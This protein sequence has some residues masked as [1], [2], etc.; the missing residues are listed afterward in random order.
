MQGVP[1]KKGSDHEL[2]K[3]IKD[4]PVKEVA[5]EAITTSGCFTRKE[6]HSNSKQSN[7]EEIEHQGSRYGQRSGLGHMSR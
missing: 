6:D 5:R 2:K 1:V 3:S 7:K 4:T